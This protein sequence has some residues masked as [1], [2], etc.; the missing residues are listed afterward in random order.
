MSAPR[1]AFAN[2]PTG[3]AEIAAL[4]A[5]NASIMEDLS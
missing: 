3:V 2:L 1:T 5:A 4:L